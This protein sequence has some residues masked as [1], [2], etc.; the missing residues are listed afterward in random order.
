VDCGEGGR[1]KTSFYPEIGEK[2]GVNKTQESLGVENKPYGA[3]R[4]K[5][6]KKTVSKVMIEELTKVVSFLRVV[7]REGFV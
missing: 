6:Q 5:K 4:S 3:P 1:R 7:I 2:I